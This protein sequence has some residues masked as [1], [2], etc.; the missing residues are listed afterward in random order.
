VRNTKESRKQNLGWGQ[1]SAQIGQR[2]KVEESSSGTDIKAV[3]GCSHLV[4]TTRNIW[5][6]QAPTDSTSEGRPSESE[7][8]LSGHFWRA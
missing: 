1:G 4:G 8:S 6:D 7:N 3:V 2:L 5:L